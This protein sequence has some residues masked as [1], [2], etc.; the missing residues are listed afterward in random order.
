MVVK[1]TQN[2]RENEQIFLYINKTSHFISD[3]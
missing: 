1:L 3:Y 2:A